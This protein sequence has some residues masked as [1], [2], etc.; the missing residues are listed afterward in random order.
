MTLYLLENAAPYLMLFVRKV[1]HIELFELQISSLF[2]CICVH[3]MH[4]WM[5][6]CARG[7]IVCSWIKWANSLLSF[8]LFSLFETIVK[9]SIILDLY[10][11]YSYNW[12]EYVLRLL[13]YRIASYC[14]NCWWH[15]NCLKCFSKYSRVCLCFFYLFIPSARYRHFY[16]YYLSI[17]NEFRHFKNMSDFNHFY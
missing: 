11:S 14:V 15:L 12:C 13:L 9:T 16:F 2:L 1:N 6:I 5:N 7:A 8:R 17:R 10:P 4:I 3:P